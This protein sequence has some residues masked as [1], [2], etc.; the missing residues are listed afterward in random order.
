[1]GDFFSMGPAMLGPAHLA[2]QTS[3]SDRRHNPWETER[4]YIAYCDPAIDPKCQ[5]GIGRGGGKS[6]Q[7]V[8][9]HEETP[10]RCNPAWDPNCPGKPSTTTQAPYVPSSYTWGN[11]MGKAHNQQE[12]SP[13]KNCNPAWDPACPRPQPTTTLVPYVPSKYMRGPAVVFSGTDVRTRFRDRSG[14]KF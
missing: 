11:S 3:S 7:A 9:S 13:D 8:D 5:K 6:F 10:P 1:M 14:R 12:V 4:N 2:G